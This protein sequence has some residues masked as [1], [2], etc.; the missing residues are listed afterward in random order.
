MFGAYI[1]I[2]G[3]IITII[4][5]IW[6]IPLFGYTGS[7]W[8]T[9]ICY[10]FM[11]VMSYQQGQKFY[12]IP[13]PRKKLITYICISALLYVFHEIIAGLPDKTAGYYN[14]IYF[15]S[16]LLFLGLFV[17]LIIKVEQKELQDYLLSENIFDPA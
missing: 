13:Y 12:P 17:L 1:T 16:G 6:W 15:G 3:A 11:M 8:A 9:F 2:G 5:N 14:F 10:A 4:L 7:A